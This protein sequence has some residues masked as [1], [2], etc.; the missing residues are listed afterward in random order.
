V[1]AQVCEQ[2]LEVAVGSSRKLR[3]RGGG[4]SG[5]TSAVDGEQH[6]GGGGGVSGGGAGSPAP[7]T[8]GA[9]DAAAARDDA[10]MVA[11]EEVASL[12]LEF[13]LHVLMSMSVSDMVPELDAWTQLLTVRATAG[14]THACGAMP[15]VCVVYPPVFA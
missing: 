11:A 2:R 4:G 8:A 6:T 5:A 7:P 10:H 12:S 15:L 3:R 1:C 14:F 9:A 13:I